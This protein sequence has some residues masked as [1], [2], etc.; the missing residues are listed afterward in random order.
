MPTPQSITLYLEQSANS[1]LTLARA[2]DQVPASGRIRAA[3]HLWHTDPALQKTVN[4]LA[5]HLRA[6][7]LAAGPTDD[8]Q[9]KLSVSIGEAMREHLGVARS[10]DSVPASERIRAVLLLWD[11]DVDIRDRI[12]QLARSN[13]ATRK[14]PH[15]NFL[16]QLADAQPEV[17]GM[18]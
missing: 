18:P 3:L 12:N 7:R 16:P 4:D 15:S 17:V 2:H 10:L 1:R 8:A 14:D 11:G 9:V 13:H 6:G 5:K